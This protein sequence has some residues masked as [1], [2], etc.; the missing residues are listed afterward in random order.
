MVLITSTI[1]VDVLVFGNISS[2]LR[3]V[4]VVWFITVCPGLALVRLLR[5][6]DGWSELAL[7][8]ALSLSLSLGV[9]LG[10]LYAG[11]W[12]DKTGVMILSVICLAGS[13]LQ[14][15]AAFIERRRTVRV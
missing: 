4:I 3:P 9:A 10:L 5:L 1:V 7:S 13:A 12:S 6:S 15:R 8:T 14:L 2:S 11:R